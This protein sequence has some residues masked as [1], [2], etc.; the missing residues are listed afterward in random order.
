[1]VT[2][3]ILSAAIAAFFVGLASGYW[4]FA[5]PTT[6]KDLVYQEHSESPAVVSQQQIAEPV[7]TKTQH[8]VVVKEVVIDS[9]NA[10]V[11]TDAPVP[12][13]AQQ[14]GEVVQLRREL[15]AAKQQVK[16]LQSA[17]QRPEEML[18]ELQ[19]RF[20][21]QD[22]DEK[23]AYMTETQVS[24]FLYSAGLADVMQLEE[25]ECKS[26]I[27]RME[28]TPQEGVELDPR[29]DWSTMQTNLQSQSWWQQFMRSNAR[30]TDEGLSLW[31]E[32]QSP[33]S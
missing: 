32:R 1:M 16:Q 28:F 22:R 9:Q 6:P 10:A 4:L 17:L 30:S 2:K 13:V 8:Q 19:A 14:Q 29:T 33:E 25:V 26:T 20:A 27:C 31:V 7:Q 15:N 3:P 12:D 21:E 18:E 24:D 11:P 5:T 23:W